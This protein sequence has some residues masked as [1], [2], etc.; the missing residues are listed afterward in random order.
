M[1]SKMDDLAFE[2]QKAGLKIN[3]SKTKEMKVDSRSRQENLLIEKQVVERDSTKVG[4][5]NRNVNAVCLWDLESKYADDKEAT[6][7]YK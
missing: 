2:V 7:F 6:D 3:A 1:Q 4:L 5:F